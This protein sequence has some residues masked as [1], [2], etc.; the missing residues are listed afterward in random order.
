MSVTGTN[1]MRVTPSDD[2]E[3]YSVV[4]IALHYVC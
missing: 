3:M 1:I 2:C 4:Y